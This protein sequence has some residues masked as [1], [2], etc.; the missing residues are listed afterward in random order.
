MEF[1][2][3]H[4]IHMDQDAF[5]VSVEIL[6]N[7]KLA[8]LPVI[9]GGLSDRGVVASCSYEARKFGVHSAMPS[10]LARQLCP[11]AIF[12]KGSMEDYSKYSHQIT[13]LLQEKVPLLE[14]ASIDE[15]YIDMTGMDRFFGCMKFAQE[16]RQSVLHQIGLPISFGLSINKTVSKMVTN[17]YKPNGEKQIQKPEV[18]SFLNPLSIKKIPGLGDSTFIKLSEMGVRKIHTLT[19]IPQDLMFKILGQNGLSLWQKANGVDNSP[20]IPYREQKSIGKQTTFDSDSMDIAG[21]KIILTDMITKL[22]FELRQKQKLTACITVTIR[23]ANFETVTQQAKIPY[24]SLDS[25]L[26]LKAKQLFDQVYQKRMLLRLVGVKL[27]HLVSGHEQIALY[28]PSEKMYNLYQSMDKMR[29]RYG[30]DTI[31]LATVLPN[32]GD[33]KKVYK[34]Q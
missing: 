3:K 18:Q 21:I 34:K 26:I 15:H 13:E 9:I 22:A 2:D 5:F 8:G 29:S 16:L 4:I 33:D 28:G 23:Y 27:S 10:R 24:T 19:Q 12:V 6:K 31:K 25:V 17:E 1:S 7:S 30:V 20:V 11:H 14:K 32:K